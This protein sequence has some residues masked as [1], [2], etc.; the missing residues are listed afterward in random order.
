[1]LI[2]LVPR[3]W[4]QFRVEGEDSLD[5]LYDSAPLYPFRLLSPRWNSSFDYS[6]HEVLS[7]RCSLVDHQSDPAVTT[8]AVRKG[9]LGV[10]ECIYYC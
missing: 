9:A 10:H 5:T 7:Y 8:K 6:N 1:M 2:F 4:R 3:G